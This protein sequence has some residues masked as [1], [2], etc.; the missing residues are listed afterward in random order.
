MT[1][2]FHLLRPLCLLLAICLLLSACGNRGEDSASEVTSDF[3]T[4]DYAVHEDSAFE[5]G[6]TTTVST[7]DG[8]GV[9]TMPF[10]A[11]YGFDP[12]ECTSMENQ[13][14]LQLIYEGLFTMTPDFGA[15]NVLCDYYEISENELTWTFYLKDACFSNGQTI[16]A[17]DVYYSLT[18]ASSSTLYS[19]RFSHIRSIEAVSTNAITVSLYTA[20]DQLPSLLAIPIVPNR[21]NSGSYIGSGPFI[22]SGNTLIPNGNWWQDLSLSIK[23]VNLVSSI[24]AEETRDYFEINRVHCVYND[25]VSNSAATYHCDYELWSSAG[26]TLQYLVFNTDESSIFSNEDVRTAVTNAIDRQDI[27]ESVYHNHAEAAVL[28]ISPS[29]GLYTDDLQTLA[30]SYGYSPETALKELLATSDFYLPDDSPVR[31]GLTVED[32]EEAEEAEDDEDAEGTGDAEDAENAENAENA[33]D[34]ENA[35]GTEAD[36]AEAAAQTDTTATSGTTDPS[37]DQIRYNRITMLV[38]EG[39]DLRVEAAE[40]TAK[41][42]EVVGFSVDIQVL[43]ETAFYYAKNQGEWDLL[44]CEATM[45]PDFDPYDLVMY[46][47][48]FN[49]GAV[50]QDDTVSTLYYAAMENSGNRYNLYKYI[51]DHGYV[52]P[53]L[54]ENNAVYTT[55]G[56][57]NG[58]NPAPGNIFYGIEN[59]TVN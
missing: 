33:E 30:A 12:Y 21:S 42:L 2:R 55:R 5:S 53:I 9:F 1:S 8:T 15:E 10:N 47:G 49:I 58:M 51:M 14:I 46:G 39:N 20:V 32:L 16:T 22:G 40:L 19:A 59:I 48:S 38:C 50:P 11:S 41:H 7:D 6:G 44:F 18:K 31:Q 23:Q 28:P 45:T 29:S 13:A 54:F 35:D 17:S 37:E 4:I 27:A 24:S 56:V 34:T 3:G 43:E 57:F 36:T 26:T 52:C 25:P